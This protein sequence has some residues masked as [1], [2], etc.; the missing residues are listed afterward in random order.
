M[1]GLRSVAP[2]AKR[3]DLIRAFPK[4]AFNEADLS[5]ASSSPFGGK[6]TMRK[7]FLWPGSAAWSGCF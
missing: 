2:F 5:F 7:L 4:E 6:S 3:E 1:S